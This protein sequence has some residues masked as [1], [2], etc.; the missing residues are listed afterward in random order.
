MRHHKSTKK[1]T[2]RKDSA[3]AFDAAWV[4]ALALNASFA[5]GTTY[6][7]LL[8]RD[9]AQV[10]QIK[11]GIEKANFQGL[12]VSTAVSRSSEIQYLLVDLSVYTYIAD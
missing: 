10:F 8:H 4:I 11:D 6:D 7:K 12:T 5:S 9:S 3:Y 1:R 2:L